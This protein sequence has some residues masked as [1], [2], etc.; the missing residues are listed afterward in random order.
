M[1]LL[2]TGSIDISHYKVPSTKIVDLNERLTQYLNSIDYAITNYKS[3]DIIV[4]C[5]NT[6]Y[7]YDYST[8]KEKA[9]KFGKV[10]EVITFKGDFDNVYQY[11][12]GYG[13]GE[14]VKYSLNNSLNLK[15]CSHFVKVTGRLIVK[16]MDQ[17]LQ[18]VKETNCFIFRPNQINRIPKN[19]VETFF[20]C[21]DK[22][23]Y[24]DYLVDAYLDVNEKQLVYLEHTFFERLRQVRFKS[25]KIMPLISG[26]SGSS[27][28]SY[29]L[30]KRDSRIMKFYT[31]LGIFNF[32]KNLLQKALSYLLFFVFY[33]KR[34]IK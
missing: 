7:C 6:N 23:I 17:I 18:P 14:I 29:D 15:N 8:L 21:V 34:L 1:V 3:I 10:L 5:E 22:Q 24:L 11:G 30:D 26:I 12:K 31:F 19:H 25:F 28:E 16:N 4:F 33:V 27:G 2:L 9:V 13:E 32:N 20:Y